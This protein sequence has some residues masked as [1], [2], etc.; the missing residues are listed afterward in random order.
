[1]REY[2]LGIFALVFLIGVCRMIGYRSED[3]AASRFAF[4]VLV[5]YTVLTPVYMILY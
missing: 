1:M 2:L 5:L 4:A 3:D